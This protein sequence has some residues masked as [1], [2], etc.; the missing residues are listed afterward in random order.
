MALALG[1]TGTSFFS[2]QKDVL[3]A[4]GETVDVGKYTITYLSSSKKEFLDR[5]EAFFSLEAQTNSGSK[6]MLQTERTFYKNFGMS[7]TRAGISS[8]PF[9]DLYIVPSE[10]RVGTDRIGFRIL[11]NPLVWWI[12]VAGPIMIVGTVVALWPSTHSLRR[13]TLT[14]KLINK[15]RVNR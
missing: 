9:E 1:I 14:K 7:A 12:W 11:I 2:T 15:S 5:S 10:T 6:I 3:L 8:T 13:F 4:P